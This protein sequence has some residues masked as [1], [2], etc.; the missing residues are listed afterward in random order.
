MRKTMTE[1]RMFKE[2]IREL[3]EA[4]LE[5]EE[6]FEEVYP[7]EVIEEDEY[8]SFESNV[9]NDELDLNMEINLEDLGFTES[10]FEFDEEKFDPTNPKC[11]SDFRK[12]RNAYF[13]NWKLYHEIL[14]ESNNVVGYWEEE[15]HPLRLSKKFITEDGVILLDEEDYEIHDICEKTLTFIEK[16]KSKLKKE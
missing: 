16:L 13:W 1:G 12:S 4:L 11:L 8:E 15:Y 7:D 10:D 5:L 2:T 14:D 6:T 3:R 9:P